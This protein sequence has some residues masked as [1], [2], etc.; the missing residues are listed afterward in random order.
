MKMRTTVR[1]KTMK[2]RCFHLMRIRETPEV[3]ED[4]EVIGIKIMKLF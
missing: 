4:R 3:I 2:K 1:R